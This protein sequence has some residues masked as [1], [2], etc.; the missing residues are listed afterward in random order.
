MRKLLK[1]KTAI[2]RKKP[3]IFQKNLAHA[4]CAGSTHKVFLNITVGRFA[5]QSWNTRARIGAGRVILPFPNHSRCVRSGVKFQ[6]F[7]FSYLSELHLCSN[8]QATCGMAVNDFNSSWFCKNSVCSRNS[9]QS[10]LDPP[11]S[12]WHNGQRRINEA[13]KFIRENTALRMKF[14]VGVRVQACHAAVWIEF[15]FDRLGV[16]TTQAS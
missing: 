5:S 6:L 10:C 7:I 8:C 4:A 1:G 9:S 3:C 13:G 15:A 16:S 11:K 14:G 2:D 12:E